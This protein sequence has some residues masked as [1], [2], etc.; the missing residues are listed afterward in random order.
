P[1]QPQL[2]DWLAQDFAAHNY[3]TRRIV[4]AIVLSRAY[5]LAPWKGPNPPPP[6]SF[7]AAIEKPLTAEAMARAARIASG[8]PPEDEAL[9]KAFAEAFPE[10]LPRVTQAT[11]QQSMFL[12]NNE[13]L[14]DLFRPEPGTTAERLARLPRADDRARAIFEAAL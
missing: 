2:L 14:A 7:A 1:S 11:I 13:A 3:D 5:Q 10:I 8:R 12:A 6:D 9:R 4:R